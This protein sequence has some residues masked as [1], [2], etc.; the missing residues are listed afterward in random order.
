MGQ[1]RSREKA[2]LVSTPVIRIRTGNATE[3]SEMAGK[4]EF[5]SWPFWSFKKK[6]KN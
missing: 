1:K 2:S 6:K 4:M 3:A 5:N